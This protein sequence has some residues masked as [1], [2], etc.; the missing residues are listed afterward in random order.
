MAIISPLWQNYLCKLSPCTM[1]SFSHFYGPPKGSND[2]D[3]I[4]RD[5]SWV[6]LDKSK[7]H[8][9]SD[10]FEC[11]M[12]KKCDALELIGSCCPTNEGVVLGCCEWILP[13]KKSIDA[14]CDRTSFG[15]ERE[16]NSD[17]W[18]ILWYLSLYNWALRDCFLVNWWTLQSTKVSNATFFSNKCVVTIQVVAVVG[19]ND[20]WSEWT[21]MRIR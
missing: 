21:E 1:D 4:K 18:G 3:S 17:V 20:C 9:S 12:N 16:Q 19:T 14:E 13:W 11:S 7:S 6:S 8:L 5:T 15:G 10:N 2:D